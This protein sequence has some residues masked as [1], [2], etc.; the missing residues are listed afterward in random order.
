[1]RERLCPECKSLGYCRFKKE[2][3]DIA[4]N[5]PVGAAADVASKALKDI[6]ERRIE[7]R[8]RACPNLNDIDP[9][10]PGKDLL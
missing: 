2:A 8:D 6:S 4:L 7:A 1:M 5:V 10:Y 3:K 9:S